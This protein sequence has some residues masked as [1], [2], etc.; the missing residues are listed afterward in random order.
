VAEDYGT[1]GLGGG[2]E[3]II[4]SFSATGMAWTHS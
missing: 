3:R 2:G 4:F 1:R